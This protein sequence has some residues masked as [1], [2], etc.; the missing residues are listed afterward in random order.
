MCNVSPSYKGTFCLTDDASKNQLQ[1]R[2]NKFGNTFINDM[3]ARDRPKVT[4]GKGVGNFRH[5]GEGSQPPGLWELPC[6]EKTLDGR[7]N[8]ESHHRL[9]SFIDTAIVTI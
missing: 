8:S 1:L 3:T 9:G 5:K 6:L 4:W 2:A 7:N